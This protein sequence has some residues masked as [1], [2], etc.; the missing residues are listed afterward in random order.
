MMIIIIVLQQIDGN[1]LAPKIIGNSVKLNGFWIIV[2][3]ILCGKI[4]GVLGMIVAIPVF[5]M[6]RNLVSEWIQKR[7]K[8][9][10]ERN[11]AGGVEIT[12][13][14][15]KSDVLDEGKLMARSLRARNMRAVFFVCRKKTTGFTVV[16]KS[17]SYE[18]ILQVL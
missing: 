8:K 16:P 7:E 6:L 4:A 9:I 14:M 11:A 12:G 10:S 13:N 1:I 18:K 15:A 2:S 3:V 17:L 5:A